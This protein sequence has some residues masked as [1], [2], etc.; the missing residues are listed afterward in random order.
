[1][2]NFYNK[3]TASFEKI[4]TIFTSGSFSPLTIVFFFISVTSPLLA[5]P[6]VQT[7]DPLVVSYSSPETYTLG[8]IS[9]E[10]NKFLDA[11]ALVALTN[12]KPGDK[13]TIPGEQLSAAIKKLW[14]QGLIADVQVSAKKVDDKT[15]NIIFTIAE[16]PRLSGFVFT[17]INKGAREDLAEKIDVSRG[18]IVNDP[19]I[20]NAKKK[21]KDYF[22]D[23]G[24]LNTTVTVTQKNDTLLSN[25]VIL[26]MHIEKKRRVRIKE[27]A[28]TGNESIKS[29]KLRRKM[30]KTKQKDWYAIFTSSK[31]IKKEYEAD[32]ANIIEYYNSKGYR[33]AAIVADT[34]K[35]LSPKF[36]KIDLKI[37]EGR[38][39]Y[40]RNINWVGNYIYDSKTLSN[41]LNIKKG[42]VYN[43]ETLQKRLSYNP[44]GYDVSSLY[45]DDG[46]L[47]FNV[48]PVEVLVDN[49]S[50]DI[51]MKIYEGPQA[52][53]NNVIVTG[54][55]K[56]HDH[57][58]L[59]EVRTLPGQ[60]FSRADLIRSTRELAALNYFDQEQLMTNGVTPVPNAQNGTVDIIYKVTEKPSDQIEL[61]GGYGGFYGLIGTLGLTFNNFSARNIGNLKTWSPLPSGD[62]QRVSL[63]V[64]ANGKSFQNYSISFTEPWL[65]GRKPKSLTVSLSHS[66]SYPAAMS[67]GRLGNSFGG[68]NF[69][70]PNSLGNNFNTFPG[71]GATANFESRLL[72]SSAS[73]AIGQRLNWPD[74]YFSLSTGLTIMQYNLRAYNAGLGF[75][76]GT[77]NNLSVS[78]TLSRNSLD[79]FT[80]PTSGSSLAL[81]LSLTPPYSLFNK[82][83]YSDP[84]LDVARRF[85]WMEYHKWMFDNT[86]YATLVPGKKRNL[87]FAARTHFGFIGSYKKSTG[88]GPFERFVMGGSGLSG[89]NFLLGTDIIGLRGYENNSIRPSSAGGTVYNKLVAEIRY[90]IQI[91]PAFSLF[92]LTF[93]EAG[94]AW[95]SFQDYNPFNAYRSVGVGARIF[96]PAFGLIGID[97]GK[98]L[99]KIPGLPN[100]GQS[101]FTFTIGQQIR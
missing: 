95:A 99:D 80:F 58:I 37:E 22:V 15:I 100:G 1:M 96:M 90:P 23:K 60:K 91:S 46:Y 97:Y 38:K 35:V 57:V 69:G 17:G 84:N 45:L 54:N 74:D 50:I 16:R 62:G 6:L 43:V 88:I 73:V 10:G 28:I 76:N 48:E 67:R 52:T 77:V 72:M 9:I 25:N 78:N 40:F 31:L 68:S 79:D 32:K 49:D 11:G 24:F 36:V 20:K 75:S 64:Q 3:I 21:A 66:R 34:I 71:Q 26:N 2:L 81:T 87:V 51:E 44:Q 39:Y 18:K 4:R 63:R 65:G 8:E 19:L 13:V 55:T 98:A 56:T 93:F 47:F 53:I 29:S 92:V 14:E 94:N 86:W 59:R 61:S 42:D 12:L 27:I 85:R 33:D 82:L 7:V 89:F 83:D 41:V 30:K 5:Q 101:A 70:G